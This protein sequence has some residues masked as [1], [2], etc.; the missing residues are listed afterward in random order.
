[1]RATR[2]GTWHTSTLVPGPCPQTT[3]AWSHTVEEAMRLNERE[4]EYK[5]ARMH[6]R[7][8]QWLG[9]EGRR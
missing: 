5:Q 1:M 4:A 3:C 7:N 9:V 6:A 8:K 2:W